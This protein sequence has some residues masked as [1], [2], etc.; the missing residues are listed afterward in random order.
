MADL[1]TLAIKIETEGASRAS[2]DL[3]KVEQSAKNTEKAADNLT[4]AM[5]NLKRILAIAGLAGGL[6]AYLDMA[7]RMQSLN[8]QLKFVTNSQYEFNSA[9]KELFAIAQNT[10]ASLE[11]TTQ[12]YI[13]SSQALKDYGYAQKDILTFTETINKAMAVGGLSHKSKLVLYS[14]YHRH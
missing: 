14:N 11:S 13:K 10:R 8:A 9:Q 1:A 7:E 5:G 3:S 4:R 6:S 12:L 2:A